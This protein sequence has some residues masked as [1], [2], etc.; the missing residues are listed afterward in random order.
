MIKFLNT[1]EVLPLRNTILRDGNLKNEE[2]VFLNDDADDT[3]HLGDIIDEQPICV[4]SFHHQKHPDFE[5]DA[6]Q[7]RGMA[8]ALAYQGKGHGNKLVNFAIVYLRGK[9]VNYI[10]CNAREKAFRFYQ[11]LGFEFVSETFD[12]PGIGPHK[13]MYLKIQ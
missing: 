2:C 3:F 5:G 7:L 6:F 11:A 1:E 8:T 13:V 4:V 12:I 9:R 10:W